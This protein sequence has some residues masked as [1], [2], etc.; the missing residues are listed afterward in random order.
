MFKILGENL[1]VIKVAEHC[2]LIKQIEI[3]EAEK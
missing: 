1:S 2:F 3:I